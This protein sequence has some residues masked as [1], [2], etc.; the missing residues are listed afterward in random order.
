MADSSLGIF[1]GLLRELS[2]EIGLLLLE[3]LRQGLCLIRKTSPVLLVDLLVLRQLLLELGELGLQHGLLLV[4]RLLVGI[5]DLK[6]HK[7]VERLA[8]VLG[9]DV[10]DSGS[11]CLGKNTSQYPRRGGQRA[12]ETAGTA[13]AKAYNLLGDVA[14]APAKTASER[15]LQRQMRHG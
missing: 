5:N 11:I 1:F 8:A 10:V 15:L 3:L 4:S 13:E 12:R 2:D 6:C 7:F 14:D 9:Y